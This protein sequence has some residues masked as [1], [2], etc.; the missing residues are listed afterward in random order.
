MN[1]DFFTNWAIEIGELLGRIKDF[2]AT[3]T[4]SIMNNQMVGLILY[5]Y[6]CIPPFIRDFFMVVLILL[7]VV[8]LHSNFKRD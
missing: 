1:S 6:G 2:F 7:I 8:T 3:F 4:N 5:L